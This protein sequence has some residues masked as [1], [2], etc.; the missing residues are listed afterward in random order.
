MYNILVDPASCST[1]SQLVYAL[2]RRAVV[3]IQLPP[4]P[5]PPPACRYVLLA[6]SATW[7]SELLFTWSL[8]HLALKHSAAPTTLRY[9]HFQAFVAVVFHYTVSTT[10]DEGWHSVDHSVAPKIFRSPARHWTTLFVD[11]PGPRLY[12]PATVADITW[13]VRR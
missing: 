13:R 6:S 8:C 9:H 2:V 4:P 11:R 12:P 1:T 5:P 3:S 7:C 10:D